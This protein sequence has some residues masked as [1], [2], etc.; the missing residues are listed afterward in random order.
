M[1]S[2]APP[3]FLVQC[4]GA[5]DSSWPPFWFGGSW[6]S[7]RF[8]GLIIPLRVIGGEQGG[9]SDLRARSQP[10]RMAEVVIAGREMNPSRSAQDVFPANDCT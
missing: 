10:S 1:K 7:T 3:R 9:G 5:A 4:G 6:T 8:T 2:G